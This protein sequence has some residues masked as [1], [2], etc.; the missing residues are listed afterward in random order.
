MKKVN[1]KPAAKTPVAKAVE[2][3]KPRAWTLGKGAPYS[4]LVHNR[5]HFAALV[6]AAANVAGLIR[7][8]KMSVTSTRKGDFDLFKAIVGK[9]ARRTWTR[10]GRVTS[11]GVTKD[12]LNEMNARLAGENA[13][14]TDMEIV[15]VMVAGIKKGGVMKVGE[16]EYKLIVPIK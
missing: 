4:A 14:A 12:G 13:F 8:N 9:S 16:T 7:L 10:S 6:I 1:T 15:K 2:N 11:N 5:K 3:V